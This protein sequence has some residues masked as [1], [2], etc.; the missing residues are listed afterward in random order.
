MTA[1][2]LYP[3]A[4]AAVITLL[5][6]PAEPSFSSMKRLKTPLRSTM[7]GIIDEVLTE[8]A[9]KPPGFTTVYPIYC[10]GL[11]KTLE[12]GKINN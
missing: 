5:M 3:G 10:C 4:Y 12:M 8:F 9:R 2:V 6:Y 7:R 1:L 11:A